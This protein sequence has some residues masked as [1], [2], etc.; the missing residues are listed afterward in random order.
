MNSKRTKP[1]DNADNYGW[2]AF[3][4][5]ADV[6]GVGAQPDDW[7]PWWDCWRTGYVAGVNTL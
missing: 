6:N 5:W 1:D 2:K 7:G 3:E 4:R